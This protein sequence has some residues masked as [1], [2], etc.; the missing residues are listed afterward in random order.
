M[1]D[2]I[3]R[4]SIFNY[5]DFNGSSVKVEI[6]L[7]ERSKSFKDVFLEK[8]RDERIRIEIK[9]T[10]M[11][12]GRIEEN[13]KTKTFISPDSMNYEFDQEC[14]NY[15]RMELRNMTTKTSDELIDL[16]PHFG[17][18]P[19]GEFYRFHP[20][21]RAFEYSLLI[22]DEGYEF[23]TAVQSISKSLGVTIDTPP[24]PSDFTYV[25]HWK[26]DNNSAILNKYVVSKSQRYNIG[27]LNI[28]KTDVLFHYS[29]NYDL[30]NSMILFMRDHV[31]LSE[32]Y[33]KK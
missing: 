7:I 18:Q 28:Q 5:D 14:L 4:D 3:L 31:F 21:N 22:P 11:D 30:L 20:D 17:Y 29:N 26:I 15:F 27:N 10:W 6:K 9:T 24:L 8:S 23:K 16:F 1:T 32:L 13:V 19:G 33:Y 12:L 25:L 2:N